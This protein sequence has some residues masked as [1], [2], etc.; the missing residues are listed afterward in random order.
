MKISEYRELK[1]KNKYR[2]LKTFVDGKE[3]SSKKE[4]GR[5]CEL[6]LLLS[7][8]EISDLRFQEKFPLCVKG[9]TICLYVSDFGYWDV[10]KCIKIV[11]DVKSPITRK[12]PVYRI[13]KK[14]MQAIYGIDIKE[15]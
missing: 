2:N 14:L 11:E 6:K 10:K 1:K 8:G 15:I 7:A 5:Y 13:K 9:W 3:F 12:N 4:A